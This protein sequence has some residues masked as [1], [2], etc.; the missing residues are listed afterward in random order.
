MNVSSSDLKAPI[1]L[2]T[3]S[4]I[5]VEAPYMDMIAARAAGFDVFFGAGL[6]VAQI[7][8][9][10]EIF[11]ISYLRGGFL[12]AC[13]LAVSVIAVIITWSFAVT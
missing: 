3:S 2:L 9:H 7:S 5:S 13:A 12:I 6:S 1:F 10:R 11:S 4:L 8:S